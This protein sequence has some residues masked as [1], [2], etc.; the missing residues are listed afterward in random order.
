MTEL[1]LSTSP[2]APFCFVTW[3]SIS[4][5]RL[6]E[7][8]P[9]T[10]KYSSRWFQKVL[11]SPLYGAGSA[12]FLIP[13]VLDTYVGSGFSLWHIVDYPSRF[14]GFLDHFFPNCIPSF[15]IPSLWDQLSAVDTFWLLYFASTILVLSFASGV[16]LCDIWDRHGGNI[17]ILIATFPQHCSDTKCQVVAAGQYKVCS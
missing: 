14:L 9:T 2:P 6:V 16:S 11:W 3:F 8:F 10:G 12:F 5:S 13:H 17:Q 4:Q 15:P 7:H 1:V